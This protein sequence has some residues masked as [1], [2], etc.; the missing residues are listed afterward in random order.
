MLG[1]LSDAYAGRRAEQWLATELARYTY[2]PGFIMEIRPDG[3]GYGHVLSVRMAVQ[4]SR[5]PRLDDEHWAGRPLGP[6]MVQVGFNERMPPSIAER[7]DAEQFAR[8]LAGAL[9][10]LERHESREWLRRDGEIY[11]DPHAEGARQ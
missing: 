7:Q 5:E 9:M 11:D 6:R 8:W 10:K 2:K 3:F 1:D 4:D